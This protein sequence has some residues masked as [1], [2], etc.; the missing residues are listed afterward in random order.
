MSQNVAKWN[1]PLQPCPVCGA[2]TEYRIWAKFVN[3]SYTHIVSRKHHIVG[4]VTNP[5]VCTQ[6]GYVQLFVDPEDFR[7][8]Q[9]AQ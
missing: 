7:D 6:C 8:D 5:L 9:I 2:N 4:S 3:S 1:I